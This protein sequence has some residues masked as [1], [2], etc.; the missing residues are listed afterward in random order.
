ME[1]SRITARDR[2]RSM[3]SLR[4]R[5]LK[6][7]QEAS[8]LTIPHLLPTDRGDEGSGRR[9]SGQDLNEAH[10]SIGARGVNN[11]A[12]KLWMAMLPINTSF[13][14]YLIDEGSVEDLEQLDQIYGEVQSELA[15]LERRVQKELDLSGVRQVMH[16]AIRHLIVAGN[17]LVH[18]PTKKKPRIFRLDSYVVRRDARGELVEFVTCEKV[19]LEQIPEEVRDDVRAATAAE[20]PQ[21]TK[22]GEDEIDVFTWGRLEEDGGWLVTQEAANVELPG[23]DQFAKDALPYLALR[24]Y[25]V[26]DEDYGRGH[27]EEYMG[28]LRAA[29]TLNLAIERAAV[30]SARV[31]PLVNPAGL[32]RI[33]TLQKARDGQY[34]PGRADDVSFLKIDKHAD[35]SVALQRLSVLEGRLEQIFLLQTSPRDAERVTAAEI[36]LFARELEDLLGGTYSLLAADLQLPL[37]KIL[38]RKMRRENR[39]PQLPKEVKPAVVTGLE[40]IG[41]GQDLEKLDRFVAGALQT[42]GDAVAPHINISEYL[43]LRKAALGIESEAL[44]KP[45]EQVA[46]ERQAEQMAALAQ[47]LGPEA[48][49]QFPD[50]IRQAAASAMPIPA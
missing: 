15:R 45:A 46:Q 9:Y 38:E 47:H 33:R 37:V 7:G 18:V 12:A 5:Y 44:V 40:A 39:F 43:E 28:D 1:E 2:Y 49:K 24:M 35:M 8:A 27:V 20:G 30:A 23:E 42:L 48:M 25:P 16:G 6:R 31:I 22:P 29:D 19:T 32:T 26:D 10:Q 13:V 3:T 41:R 50:E 36:A 11:L 17:V 4:D 21:N 34:V 14:R